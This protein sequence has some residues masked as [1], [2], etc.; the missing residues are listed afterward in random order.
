MFILDK[1]YVS[2]YLVDTALKYGYPVLK[3]AAVDDLELNQELNFYCEGFA[4]N[5]IKEGK[6]NLVYCNSENAIDW[7]TKNLD[8]TDIPRQISLCED[9][10]QFRKLISK[11]YPDFYFEEIDTEALCSVDYTK[12][13]FP[14]VLKPKIGFL[15]FGVYPIYNEKEWQNTI[16]T[17]K[18]D[19]EKYKEIFPKSV[20]NTSSFIIEEMIEGDEYAVDVYFNAE[21]K[22]VIL[23]IYKH[24]F[25]GSNDVSDRIYFTS[26]NIIKTHLE[27][28]ETLFEKIGSTMKLKNFPCH[29][30]LRVNDK[31]A[32][33][34]E[35]NP[36]RFAGWCLCDLAHYAFNINP[37][38]YYFEQ[39]RPD[40]DEIL[41]K[42]DDGLYCFTI[43][44]NQG[45]K[46]I[47]N[48]NYKAYSDDLISP[49]SAKDSASFNK[50]FELRKID[51]KN[52]PIFALAF[53][54]FQNEDEVSK[55]LNM[56]FSKYIKA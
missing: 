36:M 7:I 23:N 3:N 31:T 46:D 40:W 42:M 33:P 21:N 44:D 13:K 41:S 34:I 35:I 47:K 25:S 11:I 30:E 50:L 20:V 38:V 29:I 54:K 1:P 26:K 32:V 24:P 43:G 53:V 14:V 56:D 5:Q 37:Y 4:A 22:P 48:V 55:V 45:V 27:K 15:S 18:T 9:K 28:F 8:S 6:D 52:F 49:N 51:Y 10:V 2:S 39:K 19:I 12:L 16:Q 17:I